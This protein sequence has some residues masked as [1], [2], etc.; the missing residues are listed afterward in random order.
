MVVADWLPL[1]AV[2]VAVFVAWKLLTGVIKLAVM[3]LLLAAGAWY[4]LGN[5]A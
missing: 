2:I 5:V 4:F 1:I 3:G